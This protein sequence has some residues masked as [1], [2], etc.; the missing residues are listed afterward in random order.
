MQPLVR[1]DGVSEFPTHE[2]F[3]AHKGSH[4]ISCLDSKLSPSIKNP[5]SSAISF[6]GSDDSEQSLNV[7]ESCTTVPS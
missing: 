7:I 2:C 1:I 3:D 6:A 5:D 4:E